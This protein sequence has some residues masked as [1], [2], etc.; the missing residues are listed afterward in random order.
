MDFLINPNIVYCVLVLGI[1]LTILAL[2]SPGTGLL[3]VSALFSLI[4][5]GW[6]VYNN[7]LPINIWALIA[8]VIGVIPFVLAM[9]KSRQ[10]FFMV[11]A[12]AAFELGSIYL[13]QNDGTWWQPAINPFLALAVIIPSS[14]FLWVLARKALEAERLRPSIDLGRLIGQVGEAK[15]NLHAEGSVQV[16]GELWSAWSDQPIPAG[17]AVRVVAR[18]EFTLKVE[19][20]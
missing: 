15:T 20:A 13:F 14:A 5:A 19:K 8:L 3:E 18:R 6:G 4:L 16:A 2:L 7:R 1:M 10:I 12:I 9:R 11:I 17:T